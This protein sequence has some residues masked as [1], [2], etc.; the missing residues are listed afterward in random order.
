MNWLYD[1]LEYEAKVEY[2]NWLLQ[3]NKKSVVE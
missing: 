2:A 1:K 3:I